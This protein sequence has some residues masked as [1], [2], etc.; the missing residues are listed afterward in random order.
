MNTYKVNVNQAGKQ[1][2]EAI[3]GIGESRAG[4]IIQKR[5]EIGEF[6][7]IEDL[8]NRCEIPDEQLDNLKKVL[9]V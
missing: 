7:S 3:E 4:Q 6:K 8:Q 9:T 1:E 2:L 5:E